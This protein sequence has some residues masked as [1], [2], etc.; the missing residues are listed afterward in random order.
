MSAADSEV[1]RLVAAREVAWGEYDAAC[2]AL[3]DCEHVRA[4]HEE[5]AAARRKHL[6]AIRAVERAMTA[7][8]QSRNAPPAGETLF[9]FG[10]RQAGAA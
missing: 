9:D 1:Q 10:Q 4:W 5:M 2:R 7:A 8:A 3:P 6:E